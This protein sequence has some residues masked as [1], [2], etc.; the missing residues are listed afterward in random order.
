MPGTLSGYHIACEDVAASRRLVVS[1][2]NARFP[3][4]GGIEH[5]PLLDLMRELLPLRGS[6]GAY[7]NTGQALLPVCILTIYHE[8]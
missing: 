2:A 7:A 8:I 6:N 5:V 1:G 3:M 4:A